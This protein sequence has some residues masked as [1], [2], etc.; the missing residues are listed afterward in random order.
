MAASQYELD[1]LTVIVDRN[2]LQQGATIRETNDLEP[3]DAK[4]TAFG[5]AVV[6]VNG[7]DYGELLDV[8]SAVPFRPG[9]PTFVI[10]HTHKGHPIS[11][12]SNNVAWHHKV[13]SAAEL[14]QA[15]DE[16]SATH[17]SMNGGSP[18]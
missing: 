10:A 4:A 8:L 17:P 16:L 13:P 9:K 7:H 1:R 3:L 14:Q 2:R 11:Y 18:A 5:F 15:I 6:E 12:M